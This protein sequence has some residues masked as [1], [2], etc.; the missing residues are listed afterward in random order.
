MPGPGVLVHA[1]HVSTGEAEA[2]GCCAFNASLC[3]VVSS[4][5]LNYTVRV[6]RKNNAKKVAGQQMCPLKN[7]DKECVGGRN[8]PQLKSQCWVYYFVLVHLFLRYGFPWQNYISSSTTELSWIMLCI[9]QGEE[10]FD[11][12]GIT[13]QYYLLQTVRYNRIIELRI[14]C[15]HF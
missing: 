12:F 15:V 6:C 9:G 10:M 11:I 5:P 8:Y 13:L 3:Y 14:Q 7:G 1:C 2:E 4:R